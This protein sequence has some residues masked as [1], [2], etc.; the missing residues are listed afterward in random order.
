[1]PGEGTTFAGKL[2]VLQA[3]HATGGL[4]FK[5]GTPNG[6][7]YQS[8]IYNFQ[9]G[10]SNGLLADV[11][12]GQTANLTILSDAAVPKSQRLYPTSVDL[13]V[14]GPTAWAGGTAVILQDSAAYPFAYYPLV[15]LQGMQTIKLPGSQRFAALAPT[16]ASYAAGVMTFAASTFTGTNSIANTPFRVISGTGAGQTGIVSA[17][18]TTTVTPVTTL[19]TAL[20]NTSV[21]QFYYWIATAGAATTITASNGTF[22][23]NA[24]KQG[25]SVVII[26]G[27]GAG[28]VRAITANTSTALTV[29][30][31]DTNPD[32]TSIFAVTTN[33]ALMGSVDLGISSKAAYGSVQSSTG[34]GIVAAL[35]G[36]FSGGS[37][38]RLFGSGY[39]NY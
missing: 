28:Q 3:G 15:A 17:N 10:G 25:Y 13:E 38:I 30:T 19:L 7:P 27:T 12:F 2:L 26:A 22:V 6:G 20:D 39:A 14:S 1:M 24:L 37:P 35:L 21:V 32:N 33:P 34:T 5:E 11:L 4:A 16:V 29:A 9:T 23:A 36:T 18:T 8:V 31:W